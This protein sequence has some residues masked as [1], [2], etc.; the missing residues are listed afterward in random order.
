MKNKQLE[1][2]P[3]SIHQRLLNKARATKRPF[4]E[5]LQ[6]FAME[7]FLYR[8]SRSIHVDLFVLKGALMMRVWNASLYRPTMDIDLLGRTDN[9]IQMLTGIIQDI[10]GTEVESDGL[11]FDPNSIVCGTI[12]EDAD[13]EGVRIRFRGTLGN[14]KVVLQLDIGFGDVII[15]K[16][17]QEYFPTILDFSVPLLFSYSRESTIA[18]KFAAMV[19]LGSMNSRMKDFFDIWLLS[20]QFDFD[21][22]TL[23]EAIRSTFHQRHIEIPVEPFS[24]TKAF[25]TD[26]TKIAQWQSFVTKNKIDTVSLDFE[27]IVKAA[28]IFLEPI[29]SNLSAEKLFQDSWKAPGP[30]R[31][32]RLKESLNHI[33][34][35]YS[36]TLRKLGE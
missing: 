17:T 26:T 12:K 13:Y 36:E 6:Y 29:V 22:S 1:N 19:Q 5:V 30:W 32:Q 31:S 11:S 8:L 15:P 20:R 24:F 33:N 23:S 21:G 28:A 34:K 3:A 16:A 27:S 10:L 25:Y 35:A 9:N 14:I 18:E 7:R 4:N 2:L